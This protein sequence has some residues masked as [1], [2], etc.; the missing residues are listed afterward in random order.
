MS[1]FLEDK[2]IDVLGDLIVGA[3]KS[4]ARNNKRCGEILT[5]IQDIDKDVKAHTGLTDSIIAILNP[6]LHLVRE[7]IAKFFPG[8][9]SIVDMINA[10]IGDVYT[11]LVA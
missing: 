6:A 10:L 2:A 9:I 5:K 3:V 8:Y 4:L 11:G 1:N 7:V